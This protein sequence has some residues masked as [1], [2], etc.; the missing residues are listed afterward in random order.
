ME[1]PTREELSEI[2]SERTTEDLLRLLHRSDT[3]TPLAREVLEQELKT[4]GVS[5]SDTSDIQEHRAAT[6][7]APSAPYFAVSPL[8]FVVMSF[9]TFSLYQIYWFYKNWWLVKVRERSNIYPAIRSVFAYFFC[10]SLF[11]KIRDTAQENHVSMALPVGPLAAL[12]IVVTLLV[13]LPAPY[14]LVSFAA[15]FVL[16]PLQSVANQINANVA[17]AHDRNTRFSAGNIA[18]IVVGG[19]LFLLSIIGSFL[20]PE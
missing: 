8:K 10:Y 7:E 9:C 19:L 14:W 11:S 3:L 17:P 15:V 2:Y 16:L 12:W 20:P 1:G 18:T 4:R 6:E 13:N 5:T